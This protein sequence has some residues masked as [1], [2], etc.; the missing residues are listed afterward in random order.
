[1]I[2]N[3]LAYYDTNHSRT[4]SPDRWPCPESYLRRAE[5]AH[6]Q[7][8]LLE[9]TAVLHQRPGGKP[10]KSRETPEEDTDKVSRYRV[11]FEE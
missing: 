7:P 2:G 8:T 5:Q 3:Q 1:M 10:S 9:S 11:S 6:G 4:P